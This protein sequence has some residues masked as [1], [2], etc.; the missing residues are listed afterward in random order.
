MEYFETPLKGAYII[1]LNPISDNRGFF[2]RAVCMRELE[3]H[4]LPF[5][6]AQANMSHS[7]E[8]NTLRG[9]HYQQGQSAEIKIFRCIEG[10]VLDVII[11]LRRDSETFGKYFQIELTSDNGKCIYIPK[12]LAHGF[13][14]LTDS[15]KVFYMVSEFYS[16]D[17]SKA[18]RWDDPFFNIN[19]PTL[20][21]ILSDSDANIPNYQI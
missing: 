8:Q 4:G 9:M 21:P 18:I 16:P 7:F 17:N 2:S 15:T 14:T 12:G 10:A 5:K 1:E 20:N 13:L 6:F 19:W 11:D 3:D